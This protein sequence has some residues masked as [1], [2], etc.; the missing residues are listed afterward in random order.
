MVKPVGS[1]IASRKLMNLLTVRI[2]ILD[3]SASS[4]MKLTT[5]VTLKSPSTTTSPVNVV[6][7]TNVLVPTTCKSSANNSVMLEKPMVETPMIASAVS[8]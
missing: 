4:W 2:P 8:E 5:P 3:C 1:W 7:P 6:K